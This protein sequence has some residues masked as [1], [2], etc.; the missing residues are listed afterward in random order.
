M[1]HVLKVVDTGKLDIAFA[2]QLCDALGG[3]GGVKAN[4]SKQLILDRRSQMPQRISLRNMTSNPF[5][6]APRPRS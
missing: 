2:S 3:D 4:A 6:H 5:F 1:Q